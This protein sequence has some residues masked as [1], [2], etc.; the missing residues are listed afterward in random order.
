MWTTANRPK[1]KRDKLRY[2]S[3]LTGEE[4]AQIEA[5]IPAAKRGGRKRKVDVREVVSGRSKLCKQRLRRVMYALSTECR[6]RYVPKDLPP[7]RRLR[8]FRPVDLRRHVG[9]YP[10]CALCEE[11]PHVKCR[12]QIGREASPTTG[13]IDSGTREKRR[14]R[15][16][17]DPPGYDAGKKINR[18]KRHILVDTLGLLLHAIVHPADIQDRDGGML[19]LSTLF[20][21]YPFLQKLFAD[22]GYQG[23]I[24]QKALA[25]DTDGNFAHGWL[26]LLVI[27][28]NHHLGTELPGGAI[29]SISLNFCN[30]RD[31]DLRARFQ[32]SRDTFNGLQHTPPS[33]A[34]RI[35]SSLICRQ[36]EARMDHLEPRP[37]RNRYE[38]PCDGGIEP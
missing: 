14:K 19:V 25:I 28:D 26:P 27:F 4:W 17:I 1:Y 8:L 37:R 21:M 31:A 23:P 6:W 13:I 33:R 32:Y 16:C 11:V 34:H 30:W 2:P 36:P 20:G 29:H 35:K 7:K 3:D 15:G 22:G 38:G 9:D 24:F 5:V 18:K 12:E 10:S